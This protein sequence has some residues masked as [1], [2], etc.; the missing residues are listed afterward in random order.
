MLTLMTT[1]QTH[2]VPSV[3]STPCRMNPR[4]L[5]NLKIATF[6]SSVESWY[7]SVIASGW[8]HSLDWRETFAIVFLRLE[9]RRGKEQILQSSMRSM[10]V[11]YMLMCWCKWNDSSSLERSNL[12]H[13]IHNPKIGAIEVCSLPQSSSSFTE[14]WEYDPS[15]HRHN[16][17][18]GTSVDLLQSKSEIEKEGY[19]GSPSCLTPKRRT[20]PSKRSWNKGFSD[21]EDRSSCWLGEQASW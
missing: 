6:R 16:F 11:L 10:R 13:S 17:I 1:C 12:V 21:H 8:R 20:E 3:N 18:H 19:H 2:R 15:S 7:S 4:L 5:A 9:V 14:T